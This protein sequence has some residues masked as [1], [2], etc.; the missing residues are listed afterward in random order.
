MVE[1]FDSVE[2]SIGVVVA[3]LEEKNED[4]AEIE[5]NDFEYID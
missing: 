1:R 4:P 2:L 3:V 5:G